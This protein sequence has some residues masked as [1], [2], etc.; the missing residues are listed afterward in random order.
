MSN[1]NNNDKDFENYLKGGSNISHLYQ[2]TKVPGPAS[3]TDAAI[4][5]AARRAVDSKP[6]PVSPFGYRWMVPTSL[7]AVLVLTVSIILLQPPSPDSTGESGSNVDGSER[8]N[9]SEPRAKKKEKMEKDQSV[10]LNRKLEEGTGIAQTQIGKSRLEQDEISERLAKQARKPDVTQEQIASAPQPAMAPQPAPVASGTIIEAE[11]APASDKVVSPQE[12][13]AIV[14]D[15]RQGT[16]SEVEEI[17]AA[18]VTS[19]FSSATTATPKKWLDK[20]Q[21]LLTDNKTDEAT[22]EFRAFKQAFPDYKIDYSLY[23]SKLKEI[24]DSINK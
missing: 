3:E 11:K 24:A 20:I 10:M 7:A 23:S 8:F 13:K 4:L 1:I 9:L 2:T 12:K 21:K 18:D 16:A 14:A 19:R 22:K 15:T 17:V 6:K 5:A